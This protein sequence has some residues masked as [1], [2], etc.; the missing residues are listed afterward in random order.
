MDVWASTDSRSVTEQQNDEP[1]TPLRTAFTAEAETSGR[2]KETN[3]G[4]AWKH[5]ISINEIILYIVQS[6]ENLLR[7]RK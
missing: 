5:N 3:H 6:L 7:W 1:I 4:V 2:F